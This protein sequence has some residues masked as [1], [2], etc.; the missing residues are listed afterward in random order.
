MEDISNREDVSPDR[1][2]TGDVKMLSVNPSALPSA[3]PSAMQ[4]AMPSRKPSSSNVVP[5]N[6]EE[7]SKGDDSDGN[8]E[9]STI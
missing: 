2:T 6:D 3:M 5:E 9:G 8:D 1:D 4:S 7:D